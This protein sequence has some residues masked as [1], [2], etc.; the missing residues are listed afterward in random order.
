V[1]GVPAS[2]TPAA[3]PA[4]GGMGMMPGAMAGAGARGSE[5]R[6]ARN[7][8]LSPDDDSQFDSDQD[9]STPVL[10]APPEPI[11]KPSYDRKLG[12]APTSAAQI[13][14]EA[15]VGRGFGGR[16]PR[17]PDGELDSAAFETDDDP[18]TAPIP[19]EP[20]GYTGPRDWWSGQPIDEASR[21]LPGFDPPLQP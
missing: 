4:A 12:A 3:A 9:Y 20:A 2:A 13:K 19:L 16:G 10:G 6:S 7:K 14:G 1:S 8:Q 21:W 17:R 15:W 18:D 5:K 11:K